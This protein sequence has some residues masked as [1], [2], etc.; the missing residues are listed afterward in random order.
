MLMVKAP[1]EMETMTMTTM[2]KMVSIW[3]RVVRS[4]M[5]ITI[6]KCRVP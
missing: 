1:V 4:M 6:S 5:G 3:L 2:L